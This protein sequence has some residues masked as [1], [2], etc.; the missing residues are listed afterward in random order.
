MSDQEDLQNLLPEIQNVPKENIKQC[1]MPVGIYLQEAENL[2]NRA[3]I[4]LSQLQLAGMPEVL[5]EK[6]LARTG[7]LRT[8]QANWA[9][10]TS[11]RQKAMDTWKQEAPGMYELRDD[12]IENMEFAYR[13]DENLLEKLAEIKEGDSHADAIQDLA[14]L[15]VL[16]KH[17]PE[18]LTAIH[19][20]VTKCD[21]AAEV[22]DRM[23]GLLAAVNGQ[24][25]SDDANKLI[26]D[27]AYTLLKE[28]VD[29]VR[30]YGKFVFRKDH[31]KALSYASRYNRE[32][33]A[34]YR[35][36]KENSSVC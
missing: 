12:I 24:T 17:N 21:Q 23:A 29:E 6:L 19:F 28:T 5:L 14:N 2:H 4:D 18:P 1:D 25:Y 9:E 26:R 13:M 16:G 33:K 34:E 20:D 10:L 3:S 31:K 35:R 15:S 36:K 7:A 11:Q 32:R 30:S 27:Q 8:A 22:A